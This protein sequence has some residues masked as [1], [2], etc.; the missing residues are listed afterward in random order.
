MKRLSTAKRVGNL[1]RRLRTDKGLS[2]ETFADLCGLHRTYVGCIERGE[3]NITIETAD[4]VAHALSLTLAQ[5]FQE[6]ETIES[7][8]ISKNSRSSRRRTA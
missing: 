1:I 6:L 7:H 8:G 3:K 4:K 2:Q 5:L